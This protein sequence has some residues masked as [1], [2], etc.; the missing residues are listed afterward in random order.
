MSLI[1]ETKNSNVHR[2]KKMYNMIKQKY[3]WRWQ[4]SIDCSIRN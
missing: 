2:S 3:Y 1:P 4:G